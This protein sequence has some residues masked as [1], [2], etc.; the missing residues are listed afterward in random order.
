MASWTHR[1][2]T[3]IFKLTHR[4]KVSIIN[5]PPKIPSIINFYWSGDN[6]LLFSLST[7][8]TLKT[9]RSFYQGNWLH[10]LEGV[11]GRQLMDASVHYDPPNGFNKSSINSIRASAVRPVDGGRWGRFIFSIDQLKP[12]PFHQLWSCLGERIWHH[13]D[14][15]P[16][17]Q[18][19]LPC[20][21]T[22]VWSV[23]F[24]KLKWGRCCGPEV[25]HI[26]SETHENG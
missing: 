13:S 18:A 1:W 9:R 8:A 5:N 6:R 22:I 21:R 24:K 7:K 15:F 20:S 11:L 16:W 25:Q 23:I 10:R 3:D 19:E 14:V 17:L 4:W 2:R 26:L 12:L